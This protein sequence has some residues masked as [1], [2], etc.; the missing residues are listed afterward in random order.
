MLKIRRSRDRLIFNMGIP[1]H[2]KDGLYIETGPRILCD[3]PP[4][5]KTDPGFRVSFLIPVCLSYE[6]GGRPLNWPASPE[7]WTH[8]INAMIQ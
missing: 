8:F 7:P 5:V 6:S 4:R 1:V 3:L 2:G